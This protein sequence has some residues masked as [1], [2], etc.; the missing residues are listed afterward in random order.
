MSKIRT[1]RR[2]RQ[3]S[4]LYFLNTKK[5]RG[6][7]AMGKRELG[8]ADFEGWKTKKNTHVGEKFLFVWRGMWLGRYSVP[9]CVAIH[10]PHIPHPACI[11]CIKVDFLTCIKTKT[12]E[13]Q[14]SWLAIPQSGIVSHLPSFVLTIS[15]YLEKKKKKTIIIILSFYYYYF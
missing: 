3:G 14:K 4:V 9:A 12:R 7:A 11:K 6:K 15:L 8:R 1:L 2:F 5:R 10:H 13:P